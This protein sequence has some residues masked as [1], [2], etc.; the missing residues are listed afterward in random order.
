MLRDVAQRL[1]HDA[2]DRALHHR[3]ERAR[4][5]GLLHL[6]VQAGL[7]AQ[8]VDESTECDR[9][10]QATRLA[11]A[12]RGHVLANVHEGRASVARR[13]RQL[14]PEERGILVE[15]ALTALEREHH[16]G[17]LLRETIVQLLRDLPPL[18]RHALVDDVGRRRSLQ[19]SHQV[20]A[21]AEAEVSVVFGVRT[22]RARGHE[23]AERADGRH[24]KVR[25]SWRSPRRHRS[26]LGERSARGALLTEDRRE[27]GIRFVDQRFRRPLVVAGRRAPTQLVLRERPDPD[28]VVPERSGEHH[29]R[30]IEVA[31]HVRAEGREA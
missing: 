10:V 19:Q 7:P 5:A 31:L 2:D 30:A 20:L 26:E 22:R 15:R 23:N 24:E 13:L 14:G 1:A 3:I 28:G 27:N 18:G 11:L 12:Q 21:D 25:A 17:E 9:K 29:R 4:L 8:V 16:T 6:H